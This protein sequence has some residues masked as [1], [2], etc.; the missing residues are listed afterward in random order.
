MLRDYLPELLPDLDPQPTVLTEAFGAPV[1]INPISYLG[2]SNQ[3][4]QCHFDNAENLVFVVDGVKA[5]AQ[6]CA[7]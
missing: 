2:A 1:P 4:T 7:C 3:A 6:S 5:I